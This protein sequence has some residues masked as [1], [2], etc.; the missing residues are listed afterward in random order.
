MKR[1]AIAIAAA[2]AIIGGGAALFVRWTPDE[3]A[4]KAAGWLDDA[5]RAR[6]ESAAT[7]RPLLVK[8]GSRG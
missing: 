8:V 4:M 3:A 5:A 1:T 6:A 2:L 7:G